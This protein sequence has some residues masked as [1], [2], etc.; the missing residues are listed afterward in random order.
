M[1]DTNI[2]Y[3]HH[4]TKQCGVALEWSMKARWQDVQE[5]GVAIPKERNFQKK[6][7]EK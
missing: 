3:H 1:L 2:P 4:L 5:L 7:G 6:E